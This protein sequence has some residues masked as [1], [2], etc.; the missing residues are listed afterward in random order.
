MMA[1]GPGEGSERS[2]R[3]SG[4]STKGVPPSRFGFEELGQKPVAV[5]PSQDGNCTS[6][7]SSGSSLS[8]DATRRAVLLAEKRAADAELELAKLEDEELR[9][10]RSKSERS[11]SPKMMLEVHHEADCLQTQ[12]GDVEESGESL[13]VRA[14]HATCTTTTSTSVGSS[15]N[16]DES[17]VRAS[18]V[19][20]TTEAQPMTDPSKGFVNACALDNRTEPLAFQQQS[21]CQVLHASQPSVTRWQHQ[22]SCTCM[23][24]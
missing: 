8:T 7:R 12:T 18:G 1:D 9:L 2:Q 6:V 24:Y 11:S 14:P 10:R 20:F 16:L 21:E 13:S 5:T 23:G 19:T 15:F 22:L 3:T 4:R 17:D